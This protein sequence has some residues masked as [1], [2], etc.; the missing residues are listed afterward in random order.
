MYRLYSTVSWF[1]SPTGLTSRLV[2]VGMALVNSQDSVVGTG[3]EVSDKVEAVKSS[4][5]V[6]VLAPVIRLVVVPA[7]MQ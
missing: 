5:S 1:S 2:V 7:C 4:L 6:V 3:I